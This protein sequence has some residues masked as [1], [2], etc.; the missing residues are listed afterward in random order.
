MIGVM[1]HLDQSKLGKIG[2]FGLWFL[3]FIGRE[4]QGMTSNKAG[5]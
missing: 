1:K 4:T 5:T 3:M 2:L